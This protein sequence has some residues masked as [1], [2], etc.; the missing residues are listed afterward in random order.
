MK[1]S[2]RQ[3][4]NKKTTSTDWFLQGV[5]AGFEKFFALALGNAKWT[6]ADRAMLRPIAHKYFGKKR[7]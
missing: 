3:V 4:V 5:K 2:T 7:K 1:N 6:K